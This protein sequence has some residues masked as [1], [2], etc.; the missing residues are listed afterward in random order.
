MG[1]G[2]FSKANPSSVACK[3][4]VLASLPV[5]ITF[6]GMFLTLLDF[7]GILDKEITTWS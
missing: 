4:Q 6:T 3:V 2:E 7:I 1:S 5:G